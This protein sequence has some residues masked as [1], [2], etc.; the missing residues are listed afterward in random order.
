M[1]G[2]SQ[3]VAKL[4]LVHDLNKL[5]GAGDADTWSQISQEQVTLLS[6]DIILMFHG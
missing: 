3:Y 5:E 4:G 6:H 1:Q 2:T